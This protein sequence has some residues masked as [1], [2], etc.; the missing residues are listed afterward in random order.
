MKILQPRRFHPLKTVWVLFVLA[1]F[2]FYTTRRDSPRLWTWDGDAFGSTYAVK[3][4]ATGMTARTFAALQQEIESCL[5]DINTHMSTWLPTS[6]LS[7]FNNSTNLEP[8]AMDTGLVAVTEA[9]LDLSRRSG[10]AFD[11][12]FAPMFALWGFGKDGPK[13]QPTEEAIR[14]T[15]PKCGS[16]HLEIVS[17]RAIRKTVPG[18]QYNLNAI[19]PGYA[20]DRI[21][22]ILRSRG[23]TNTYVDVGGELL[24][25]GSSP[26]GDG[27]RIG[28]ETPKLDEPV[29]QDLYQIVT[30]SGWAL[31]TSG[32]YRSYGRDKSGRLFSHI[33]DPRIGRPATSRVASVSVIA[34]NCMIADGLATT[35]F[36][37]GAE[38]GLAWIT[39][40]AP[41]EAFFILHDETGGLRSVASAGFQRLTAARAP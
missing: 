14:D 21:A 11:S 28:I 26:R 30:L 12:A 22:D 2:I 38:E 18:L 4:V 7:R 9:A 36:V 1:L 16:A 15:L 6:D 33:F 13:H 41:A 29:G 34:T 24:L 37:M 8:F 23:L 27:W 39:N 20:A 17:P 5:N 32:D 10:G 19:A 25:S 35:L 40:M 31:A 3:F